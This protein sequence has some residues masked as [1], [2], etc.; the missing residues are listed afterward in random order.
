[1]VLVTVKFISQET[2]QFEVDPESTVA[3]LKVQL[4]AKLGPESQGRS[5]RLVKQG[6][7]LVDTQAIGSLHLT[8]AD[9]LVAVA[10]GAKAAAPAG[11]APAAAPPPQPVP[12]PPGPS[13]AP[14]PPPPAA[15]PAPAPASPPGAGAYGGQAGYGAADAPEPV[16]DGPEFQERLAGLIQF[17]QF[18]QEA[19]EAA[20]RAAEGNPDLAYEYLTSPEGIPT[21]EQVAQA[22]AQDQAQMQSQTQQMLQGMATFLSVRPDGIEDVVQLLERWQPGIRPQIGNLISQMGLNPADFDLD[23]VANRRL[24]PTGLLGPYLQ[25][26]MSL[27]P[28]GGAPQ[29]QQYRPQQ[30]Q[31]QQY[32]QPRQQAAAPRPA[33]AP[34][35]AP[36]AAG[37]AGA[38]GA[39]PPAA[40]RAAVNANQEA[41]A[42]F[43][44]EE[45]EAIQRL[46]ELGSF[47]LFQ[48]LQ[49]YEASEKNEQFA[50]NL[51]CQWMTEK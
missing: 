2:H 44:P 13:T 18:P 15:A 20:L 46:A 37:A 31:Q 42:R 43:T 14:L 11:G 22:R 35:A 25:R 21:P 26:A 45:R 17:S 7:I 10:S 27:Q 12:A 39:A 34:A 40:G 23:G 51:L 47:P 49:A 8:A 38:G 16:L 48:V 5:I 9:F 1:M 28:Q 32:Q 19:C 24:Q 36:G 29:Q 3:Q 4:L 6:K 50:A 30:Q 41:L 33:P